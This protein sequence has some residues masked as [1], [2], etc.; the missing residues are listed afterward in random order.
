VS[1]PPV[2]GDLAAA[3]IGVLDANWTG[4]YTLPATGLYPHQWSWDAAFIAI[5]LRHVSPERAQRELETL[6][7]GQWADGRIPQIVYDVSGTKTTP[8]ARRSGGP[9]RS[10]VHRRSRPLG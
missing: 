10:R 2:A 7:T 6:L 9:R 5:G 8:R 1:A 3:A 4:S